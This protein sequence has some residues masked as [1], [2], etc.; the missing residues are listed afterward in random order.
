MKSFM[1]QMGHLNTGWNAYWVYKYWIF[2]AF[3]EVGLKLFH[4]LSMI[5]KKGIKSSGTGRITGLP[6]QPLEPPLSSSIKWQKLQDVQSW[7]LRCPNTSNQ[8]YLQQ[9]GQKGCLSALLCWIT[10][11]QRDYQLGI[12]LKYWKGKQWF[13]GKE[14][15]GRCASE[16]NTGHSAEISDH[17]AEDRAKEK[18]GNLKLP[19]ALFV[20]RSTRKP[21]VANKPYCW[22][23]NC[24]LANFRMSGWN[25][26][27]AWGHTGDATV[28]A[29]IPACPPEKEEDPPRGQPKLNSIFSTSW[30]PLQIS[31]LIILPYPHTLIPFKYVWGNEEATGFLDVLFRSE[32]SPQRGPFYP[33]IHVLLP[34]PCHMSFRATAINAGIGC[35][36]SN[37]VSRRNKNSLGSLPEKTILSVAD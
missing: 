33:S 18:P 31:Q 13:L 19:P 7:A 30:L 15:V 5:H 20:I 23:K 4:F 9:E 36:P 29:A 22:W 24:L 11:F 3:K 17:P 8:G 14:A 34:F 27:K 12:A 6:W 25:T 32:L 10:V 37:A 21:K 35:Q 2:L 16:L 26:V 1:S 28:V